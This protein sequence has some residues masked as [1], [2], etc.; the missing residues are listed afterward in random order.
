MEL[1]NLIILVFLV[2]LL[3]VGLG[4]M[5]TLDWLPHQ[6]ELLRLNLHVAVAIYMN[7]RLPRCIEHLS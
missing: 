1:L 3:P 6:I 2:K 7:L 4:R 5:L